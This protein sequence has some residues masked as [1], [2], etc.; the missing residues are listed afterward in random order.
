MGKRTSDFL[1]LAA[2]LSG[3]LMLDY[4]ADRFGNLAC[5]DAAQLIEW[6]VEAGFAANRIRPM[7]FGGDMGTKAVTTELIALID[8]ATPVAVA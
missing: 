1:A 5:T 2:I 7:E 3:A 4:L 6:A 8:E